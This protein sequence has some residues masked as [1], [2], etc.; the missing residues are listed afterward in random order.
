MP[1]NVNTEECD[2]LAPEPLTDNG[3][4]ELCFEPLKGHAYA[5]A[6][7]GFNIRLLRKHLDA[8]LFKPR[9][10]M[11]ALDLAIEVLFPFTDFHKA[12]FEMFLKF[13]DCELTFE[14][15]QMLNALG[16]KT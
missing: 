13:A 2:D 8:Q 5:A 10:V 12:S 1:N 15:E 3:D 16:I 9:P 14:E 4:W 7:M 11:E 6:R